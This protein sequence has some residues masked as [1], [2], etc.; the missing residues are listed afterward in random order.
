MIN[1]LLKAALMTTRSKVLIALVFLAT[2]ILCSQ[3]SLLRSGPMVGYGQMTEV[4]LWVQTTK[5][6]TVQLRYWDVAEPGLRKMS[7]A[8]RTENAREN[9]AHILIRDL[10]PGKSFAYELLIN[11]K[12]VPRPY[13]LRFQTQGLWQ[14][15]T[16]PP[17]F[18]AAF[19]SCLYI[20]ET[21]WDRP[22]TPYGSDYEILNVIASKQP[23][24]MLWL[25]D[26]TYYREIDWNTAA[27]LR[28]R[29]NHT[30][31]IPELQ[32]ILGAAHNYAIWD[33]HDYGPNDADRSY[34]L[35]TEALET[36]K[37]F[38]ANQ[39][40]GI[41]GT[42]GV[43]GRFE[44]GD[45]EFFMLDDRYHRSPNDALDDAQKTMFGRDQLQWL[46]D[47]L[48]SSIATFKMVVNGNQM[49]NPSTGGE[50]FSNYRSEYDELLRFIRDRRIPGVVFLS[51][52]RHLSE[53]IVL[54]DSA[55]YPLYDYTSSSLTAGLSTFKEDNPSIV[56]GTLVNDAHS[57]GILKF[58]G[59][60]K[61]RKLTMECWDYKGT[62]RWTYEIRSG[63]LRPPSDR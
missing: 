28:H 14:W 21:Q 3:S 11:G 15:R 13:P 36:H 5:E 42:D 27:G 33:D 25:G 57:F 4:M 40:Y 16:D 24:L 6:A 23:D 45:V 26:N 47:G 41:P 52:D 2:G 54:K 60:G 39:T 55:F 35:K 44:W 12:L 31:A 7:S 61:D 10:L 32:P 8:V 29:W 46:K 34:R 38:W 20:N 58:S 59:P 37:L 53:L 63:Q 56:P 50:T 18:S 48:T 19:G 51:G 62:L 49:L 43:F 30:R 9:I 1:Q 22:G 17:D